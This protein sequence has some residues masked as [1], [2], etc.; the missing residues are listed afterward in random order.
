VTNAT[1][2]GTIQHSGGKAGRNK[3]VEIPERPFMVL[4]D[5]DVEEI[6][7]IFQSDLDRL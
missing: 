1:V 4:T 3:K 5:E 6:E 2:Y 7:D